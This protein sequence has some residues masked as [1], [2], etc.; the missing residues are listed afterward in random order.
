M[1]HPPFARY[2]TREETI[3]KAK[4]MKTEESYGM[5]DTFLRMQGRYG[6][7][8]LDEILTSCEAEEQ[9]TETKRKISLVVGG[10]GIA[11]SLAGLFVA[12]NGIANPSVGNVIAGA[13]AFGISQYVGRT[14]VDYSNR[15]EQEIDAHRMFQ[16]S[17]H[18]LTHFIGEE[19]TR[20]HREAV[21]SIQRM[22][23]AERDAAEIEMTDDAVRVGDFWVPISD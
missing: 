8:N 9:K 2:V 10:L 19:R 15:M 11:A 21:E 22:S 17:L 7:D 1:H 23:A 3:A 4:T 14:A 16:G 13:A 6:G 20:V 5:A 12:V 18:R